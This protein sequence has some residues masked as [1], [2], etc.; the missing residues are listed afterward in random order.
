MPPQPP[1]ASWRSRT[2][3]SAAAIA[4]ARSGPGR[5]DGFVSPGRAPI[6]RRSMR[7]GRTGRSAITT[8][9]ATIVWRAQQAK[10]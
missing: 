2:Q 6:S 9:R 5:R 3:R 1:S 7:A 4:W 10:S 8:E